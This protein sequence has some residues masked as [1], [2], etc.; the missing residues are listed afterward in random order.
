MVVAQGSGC[1]LV[2]LSRQRFKSNPRQT[3]K[4]IEHLFTFNWKAK[5]K[6]KKRGREW[7]LLKN[8]KIS[9]FLKTFVKKK[10]YQSAD[11][12]TRLDHF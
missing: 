11:V 2:E 4:T 3:F 10:Q 1:G 6:L 7:P 5:T 9:D 8:I 12:V